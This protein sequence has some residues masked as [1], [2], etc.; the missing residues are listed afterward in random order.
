MQS[1]HLCPGLPL[2]LLP[3]TLSAS[4]LFVNRIPSIISTCPVHFC[5]LLTSL[6]FSLTHQLPPSAPPF[7]ACLF[8]SLAQFSSPSYSC[9]LS[10]S[11]SCCFLSSPW[12]LGRISRLVFCMSLS[13]SVFASDIHVYLPSLLPLSST[14]SPQLVFFCQFPT[15]CRR[16]RKPLHTKLSRRFSFLPSSLISRS[17]FCCATQST[18]V[19]SR[20]TLSPCLPKIS[21][22]ST[23]R[24]WRSASLSTTTARSSAYINLR[25]LSLVVAFLLITSTTANNNSGLSALPCPSPLWIPPIFYSTFYLFICAFDHPQLRLWDTHPPHC[26]HVSSYVPS[27]ILTSSSGT[28]IHLNVAMALSLGT[29]SYA[30]SRYMNPRA[31]FS[32][33]SSLFSI[34]CLRV[35]IS[36]T[37][38]L[39]RLMH[40]F[41]FQFHTSLFSL[42]FHPESSLTHSEHDWANWCLGISQG[43]EH[44]PFFSIEGISTKSATPLGYSPLSCKYLTIALST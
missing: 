38:P 40:C 25:R 15:S 26:G 39:P 13:P 19:F 1:S 37:L 42:T 33:P 44:L 24:S 31:I 41:F 28:P 22:H 43:R 29:M 6:L 11:F 17:V 3:S 8:F 36:S 9:K 23:N 4:A 14:H 30:F 16:P 12:S 34:I 21:F 18:P 32:C 27:T 20:L 2:L 35:S 7:F 10:C 5:W